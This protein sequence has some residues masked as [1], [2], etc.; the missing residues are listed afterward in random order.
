[1]MECV[2]VL[3]VAGLDALHLTQAPVPYIGDPGLSLAC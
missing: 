1:M 3:V 2:G